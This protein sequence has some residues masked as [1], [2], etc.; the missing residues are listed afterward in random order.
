M[1]DP[2]KNRRQYSRPQ[3]LWREK[4]LTEEGSLKDRYGLKSGREIWK[5]K[6]KLRKFR[7]E[8]RKILSMSGEEAKKEKEEL[9]SRLRRL[10]I[11]VK[12]LEDVL[13]LKIE[14]L[15][16]RRLE[17][18]VFKK[19]L[20][21]T[22]KQGRQFITHGHVLV[23]DKVVDIPSYLVSKEKEDKIS[24]DEKIE[25]APGEEEKK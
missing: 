21:N 18:L 14:D 10:G 8:A 13:A 9:L 11:K 1:G 23:E 4:R 19:G 6:S 24:L 20:A 7:K 2:K 22:M 15:L 5:S 17:T 3:H 12:D 25:I 16:D